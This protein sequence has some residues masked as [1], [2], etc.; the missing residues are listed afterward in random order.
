MV[1]VQVF[2]LQT[3]LNRTGRDAMVGK[4]LLSLAS[5]GQFM[6]KFQTNWLKDSKQNHRRWIMLCFI[7]F[8][9]LKLATQN[10][11]W[12][13]CAYFWVR[14]LSGP[15][16]LRTRSFWTRLANQK[17]ELPETLHWEVGSMTWGSNFGSFLS[18]VRKLLERLWSHP[19][20][21]SGI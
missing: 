14:I 1:M 7:F 20:H 6:F 17:M 5:S 21:A 11:G 8:S 16:C 3:F 9:G 10:C 18:P 12:F 13:D 2:S 19:D 4:H 15:S